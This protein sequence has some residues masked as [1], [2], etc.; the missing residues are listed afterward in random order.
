M[1]HILQITHLHQNLKK[2]LICNN[3]TSLKLDVIIESNCIQVFGQLNVLESL[4]SIIK[5][6]LLGLIIKYCKNIKFLDLCEFENQITYKILDLIENIKQN[7]NYLNYLSI[8]I[9]E[10]NRLT[11]GSSI[12]LKNLGQALPSK[13]EYLSLVLNVKESD[14][15]AFLENSQDVFINK[16][17]IKLQRG[18]DDISHYIREYIMKGERVKYLAIKGIKNGNLLSDFER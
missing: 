2:I 1:D 12:I 8:D 7:L 4:W 17:F 6:R 18:S 5:T 13:L 15:R 16:L 11:N 14:F 10:D 3:Y 9:Q